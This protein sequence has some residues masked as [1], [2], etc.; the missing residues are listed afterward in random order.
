MCDIDYDPATVWDEQAVRAR[1]PHECM[2]CS[3]TIK[4]GE[5]YVRVGCLFEGSWSTLIRCAPCDFLADAIETLECGDEGQIL[6][7][8]LGEEIANL[9]QGDYNEETDEYAEHWAS[10]AFGAICARTP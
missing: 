4:P 5:D 1:R 7:G 2:E 10:V 9:G 6:F 3:G 8:G